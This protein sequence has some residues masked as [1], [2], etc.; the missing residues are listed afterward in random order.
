MQTPCVLNAVRTADIQYGSRNV[1]AD[2]GI[3]EGIKEFTGWPTIPQVHTA[4]LLL[5]LLLHYKAPVLCCM[6][7]PCHHSQ[8]C[9]LPQPPPPIPS[10]P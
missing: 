5:L 9:R 7:P 2:P 1:L 4:L 8:G 10:I 3:R 6:L